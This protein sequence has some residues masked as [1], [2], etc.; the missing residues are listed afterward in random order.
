[1]I[2]VY[3]EIPMALGIDSEHTKLYLESLSPNIKVYKHPN[4]TIPSFWTHHEKSVIIDQHIG[5]MGGLDICFGRMDNKDH[6]LFDFHL[7][8]TQHEEEVLEY[9][10]GIDYANSRIRDFTNVKNH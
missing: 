3:N 7:Q 8:Q 1:M 6:L 4:Q 10:P 9:W 5:F 2:V